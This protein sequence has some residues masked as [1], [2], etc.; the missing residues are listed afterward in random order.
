MEIKKIRGSCYPDKED[1][2][3]PTSEKIIVIQEPLPGMPGN[4]V[5]KKEFKGYREP[6]PEQTDD[7]SLGIRI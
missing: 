1:E 4:I 7:K 3:K 2:P 5:P 6:E